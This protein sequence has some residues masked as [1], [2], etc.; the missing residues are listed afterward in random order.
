MYRIMTLGQSWPDL[1]ECT[2]FVPLGSHGQT[3][4]VVD[5][6]LLPGTDGSPGHQGHHHPKPHTDT[7]YTQ[8]DQTFSSG[9]DVTVLRPSDEKC[10]NCP[11]FS[12]LV[13]FSCKFYKKFFLLKYFPTWGD[14]AGPTWCW[15]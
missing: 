2:V 15:D 3:V 9:H 4:V 13:A 7:F 8:F 12:E 10:K 1:L 11:K 14:P 6:D 5:S